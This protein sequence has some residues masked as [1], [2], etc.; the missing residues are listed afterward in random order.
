MSRIRE[1]APVLLNDKEQVVLAI[2]GRLLPS[3]SSAIWI[4]LVSPSTIFLPL[5]IFHRFWRSITY[6]VTTQRIL[7][8]ERQ[9]C[10]GEILLDE[11][12]KIRASKTSMMVYGKSKKLWLSR[13]PDAYFFE[14]L[15]MNVV[16]K[17]H[18]QRSP[19]V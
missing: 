4:V 10:V 2:E 16:E 6:I 5:L 18:Q 14:N 13:L 1:Y 17:I 12:V 3:L 7:I 8:V 11:I 9:G 15:I 19:N